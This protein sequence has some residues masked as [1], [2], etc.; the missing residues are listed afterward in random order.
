MPT[1]QMVST[2]WGVSRLP[3]PIVLSSRSSSTGPL[4]STTSC[5]LQEPPSPC[6]RGT[7]LI[8]KTLQKRPKTLGKRP[9]CEL[10]SEE[11]PNAPWQWETT[12][13]GTVDSSPLSPTSPMAAAPPAQTCFQFWLFM[14]G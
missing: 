10:P 4:T 13:V 11:M 3:F 14:A 12:R 6:I 9:N 1:E 8:Q 7:K 5:L 2:I